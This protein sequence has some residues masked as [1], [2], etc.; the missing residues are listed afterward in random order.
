M[1]IPEKIS[2]EMKEQW[3]M[4]GKSEEKK[5]K[6]KESKQNKTWICEATVGIKD[7]SKK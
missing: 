4:N 3:K 5:K 1:C 7:E 6:M 2:K